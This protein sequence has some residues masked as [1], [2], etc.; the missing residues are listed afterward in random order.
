MRNLI[1]EGVEPNP[2]PARKWEDL[3]SAT[4]DR[5]L[6]EQ[7]DLDRGVLQHHLEKIK[8][9][10][11]TSPAGLII[12]EKLRDPTWEPTDVDRTLLLRLRTVDESLN[13]M[14]QGLFQTFVSHVYVLLLLLLIPSVVSSQSH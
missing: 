12:W 7:P 9:A 11:G 13:K 6:E 4:I 8:T 2:G 14:S 1:A 5:C 3:V 10:M